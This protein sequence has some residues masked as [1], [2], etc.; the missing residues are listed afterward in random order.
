[1]AVVIVLGIAIGLHHSG[2]AIGGMDDDHGMSAAIEMCLGM[3]TAVGAAVVAFA[4][5]VLAL[6]R[7]RPTPTLTPVGLRA[8]PPVPRARAGPVLL[9]LLCVSRR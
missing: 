2:M 8:R 5:G 9:C 3:M 4:L 7:W 6:G 1:M